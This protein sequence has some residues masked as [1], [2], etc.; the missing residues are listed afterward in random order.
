MPA[1]MRRLIERKTTAAPSTH[2]ALPG[3]RAHVTD[4]HSRLPAREGFSAPSRAAVR[5]LPERPALC[6]ARWRARSARLAIRSRAAFAVNRD[7]P[8]ARSRRL[9]QLNTVARP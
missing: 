3:V 9:C 1:A 7:A 4:S 5:A 2:G 8:L 6:T